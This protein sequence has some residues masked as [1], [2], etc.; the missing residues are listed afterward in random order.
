MAARA[1]AQWACAPTSPLPVSARRPAL[2]EHRR[3]RFTSRPSRSRPPASFS[4][5]AQ[6]SAFWFKGFRVQEFC[7]II[8]I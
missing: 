7:P 5:F 8:R 3:S 1:S 6:Q 2:R 4:S